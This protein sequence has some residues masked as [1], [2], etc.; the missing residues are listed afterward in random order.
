MRTLL[1]AAMTAIA[2]PASQAAERPTELTR[3]AGLD[4]VVAH[5]GACH[6]LDYI[7][8]NGGFLDVAGW[9]AE[10]AKMINA[11]GAPIDQPDAKVIAEYLGT[12]YGLRPR[13]AAPSAA[14]GNSPLQKHRSAGI[15]PKGPAPKPPRREPAAALGS[16]DLDKPDHGDRSGRE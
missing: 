7:P 16:V 11:F 5:C 13:T 2:V 10:V 9:N 15:R 12:N 8:M 1:I 3:G 14:E 6:S 4:K